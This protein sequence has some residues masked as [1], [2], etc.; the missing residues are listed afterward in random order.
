MKTGIYPFCPEK[1]LERLPAFH[2]TANNNDID[3]SDV[4]ID[5]LKGLRHGTTDTKV[6]RRSK[7]NVVPGKRISH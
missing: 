1:V 3:V 7:I 6:S 5:F 4:L 2:V